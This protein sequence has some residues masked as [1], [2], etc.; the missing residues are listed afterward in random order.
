MKVLVDVDGVLCNFVD[1]AIKLHEVPSPFVGKDLGDGLW[2]LYEHMGMLEDDFYEPMDADFWENLEKT[3]EADEIIELL[4]MHVG[5]ENVV[6]ITSTCG[7]DGC[8]EGKMNWRDRHFLDLPMIILSK[9][10]DSQQL[11]NFCAGANQILVDDNTQNV[12]S[13]IANGGH[14]FLVPRIWN[15]D[16]GFADSVLDRLRGYLTA[17][18]PLS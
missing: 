18:V 13:F 14:A 10:A 9:T 11:K 15:N 3:P 16:Y 6:L 12:E 17:R 7:T 5:P 8:I 4:C 2:P 1:G